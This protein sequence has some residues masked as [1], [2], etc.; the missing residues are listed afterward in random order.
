MIQNNQVGS[1]RNPPRKRLLVL[2]TIQMMT[3]TQVCFQLLLLRHLDDPIEVIEQA[4]LDNDNESKDIIHVLAS[5][6]SQ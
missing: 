2:K 1:I 5:I 6:L 4:T 3:M